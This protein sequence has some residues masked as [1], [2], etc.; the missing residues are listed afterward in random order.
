MP[1]Y[2]QLT[3]QQKERIA[4]NREA[5]IAK[6]AASLQK[7]QQQRKQQQQQHRQ[8]R[9][10]PSQQ[11][12]QQQVPRTVAVAVQPQ[13]IQQP[14]P[15]QPP[16][17]IPPHQP[18]PP[19]PK[20]LILTAEQQERIRQN[21]AKAMAK[22]NAAVQRRP[23]QQQQ[24]QQQKRRPQFQQ[25]Q[26]QRQQQQQQQQQ[27]Q[28]R[29]RQQQQQQQRQ[30]QQQQHLPPPPTT[31]S[32]EIVQV[33]QQQPSKPKPKY[34]ILTAEQQERIRQNREK[35]M[36]KRA[37]SRNRPQQ[38][39]QQQ[40][41]RGGNGFLLPTPRPKVT[42][43]KNKKNRTGNNNPNNTPSNTA[44]NPN[45][46][47]YDANDSPLYK[48][49]GNGYSHHGNNI[50]DVY[51]Q[52]IKSNAGH[53]QTTL[54]FHAQESSSSSSSSTSVDVNRPVNTKGWS[55]AR[56]KAQISSK[57]TEHP[58]VPIDLETMKTW[59]YP[60]NYQV[61][62]YQRIIV[63]YALLRNTLVCL[64]TG[65]GKTFIAAVV[66]YNFNRWFP[67]GKVIFMAPTKPLVN[68]QVQAC[69]DITGIPEDI[70]ARVNGSV[71]KIKSERRACI[72]YMESTVEF[73][74]RVL[75]PPSNLLD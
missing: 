49:H 73:K 69:H 10:S 31:T 67:Q 60:T 57:L 2:L 51:K 46:S 33:F 58:M 50:G 13:V 54:N 44:S 64:P 55:N 23:Q 27:Q 74:F 24:Q 47:P 17:Y 11:Q 21:R 28:A 45:S 43:S 65:L 70:T 15:P 61:R 35:A 12:Q 32:G 22:K 8:P 42:Q 48:I 5:A 62:K 53:H 30:Q 19:K 68:Q 40:Q 39:Q 34:L 63:E 75:L 66:M 16:A 14:L 37:A 71:S 9:Q 59:I 52:A 72:A 41:Q 36:A 4:K 1:S 25:Q 29:Q 6:R 26:Q 20:Y 38:Q 7:Q 18:L 56:M 3:T